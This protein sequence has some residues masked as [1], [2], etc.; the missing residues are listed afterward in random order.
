M[1]S[2]FF[3]KILGETTMEVNESYQNPISKLLLQRG[4]CS[5]TDS[6]QLRLRFKCSEKGN[7]KVV[8]NILLPLFLKLRIY[9][10]AGQV[11]PENNK[12]V[13]KIYSVKNRIMFFVAILEIALLTIYAASNIFMIFL[14]GLQALAP[15]VLSFIISAVID[16]IIARVY[17]NQIVNRKEDLE[18]MKKELIKRVEAIE[19]WEE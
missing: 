17:Y 14:A 19:H 8:N 5:A 13:I 15:A 11:L 6:N 10:V 12:T 3:R 7:I 1:R 18:V 4:K 2:M 9:Y 16:I